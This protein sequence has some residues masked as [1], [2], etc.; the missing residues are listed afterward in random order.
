M[1]FRSGISDEF[2]E[3]A[4]GLSD[5]KKISDKVVEGEKGYYI[6]HLDSLTPIDEKLFQN[7]KEFFKDALLA[8]K[9]NEAFTNFLTQLQLKA[10]LKDN[11]SAKLKPQNALF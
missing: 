6:L 2:Q 8:K 3:T 7:D 10:K 1:L 5:A 4:F 11:V 9:K